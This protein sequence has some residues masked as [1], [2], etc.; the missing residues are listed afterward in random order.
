MVTIDEELLSETAESGSSLI[1][2][3][4]LKRGPTILYPFMN[5]LRG[6]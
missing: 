1:F 5:G 2:K 6:F 3:M 4:V